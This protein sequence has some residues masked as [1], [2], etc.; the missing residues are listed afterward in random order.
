MGRKNRV[1]AIAYQDIMEICSTSLEE[2]YRGNVVCTKEKTV[3]S[4]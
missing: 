2:V 1:W 4:Y 3:E